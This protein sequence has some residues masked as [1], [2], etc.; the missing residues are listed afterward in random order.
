VTTQLITRSESARALS[1]YPNTQ[2]SSRPRTRSPSRSAWP[3]PCPRP[4]RRHCHLPAAALPAQV[5]AAPQVPAVYLPPFYE[6][7]RSLP[8]ALLR[9]HATRAEPPGRV[10]RRR[11]RL[12]RFAI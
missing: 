9:P 6:A 11:R 10:R 4:R 2:T 7:E 5:Q 1:S 3:A 12:G 8:H